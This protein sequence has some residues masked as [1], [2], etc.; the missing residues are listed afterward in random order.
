MLLTFEMDAD[1]PTVKYKF[2]QEAYTVLSKRH[3]A[4]KDGYTRPFQTG[5]T[6]AEF[7]KYFTYFC[8]ISYDK[9]D[10][11]FS[12]SQM[13]DY[14]R[15]MDAKY[16]LGGTDVDAFIYDATNSLCIMYQDGLN[17]GFIHRSFQEY[18]CAKFFHNQLD[19]DLESVIPIFDRD[20]ETKK[21]DTALP[22]LFDMKPRAVEK[23]LIV[24]YLRNFITECLCENGLWT[25]LEKIYPD[26]EIADGTG[27]VDDDLIL[28][29][30][31]LYAF[32]L[33]HYNIPLMTVDPDGL[34]GISIACDETFVY[35]EDTE[36]DVPRY[37]VPSG[38]EDYYGEPEET[39]HIYRFDWERIR[40]ASNY[41]T[42]R[43]SIQS[44]NSPFMQ[45][46]KAIRELLDT[47]TAKL[48]AKPRSKNIFDRLS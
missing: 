47:L 5:W 36:E 24:P 16:S 28:P 31:N 20:D 46:Y 1:V 34:D 44:E 18:F 37:Q 14:F 11:S 12:R 29:H 23:Y 10:I 8:A 27:M 42:L 22:M 39:G 13:E 15:E 21:D 33:N 6:A 41:S 38:Y 25:F 4:S 40:S 35:R 9:S 7:E 43:R 2:Y 32:V 3:D 45:E 26:Y 19:E 17:Y 48:A 30:S